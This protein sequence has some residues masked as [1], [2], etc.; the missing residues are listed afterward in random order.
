VDKTKAKRSDFDPADDVSDD[1]ASKSAEDLAGDSDEGAREH[2]VD[3][4]KSKLRKPATAV[5]G[6]QY[7]GSKVG[8]DAMS[9]DVDEDDPFGRD[10]GSEDGEDEPIPNGSVASSEED[11]DEEDSGTPMTDDDDDDDNDDDGQYATAEDD[12]QAATMRRNVSK[13][14]AAEDTMAVAAPLSQAQTAD[15]EK[16]RAV[17][18]QRTTFDSLLG[19]RMKMQKSLIGANTLVAMNGSD[20]EAQQQEARKALGAAER[21]AFNLWASLNHFRDEMIA[22]RTGI[23]REHQ[24]FDI[25]TSTGQ[26]WSHMKTQEDGSTERRKAV[27]LKWSAKASGVSNEQSRSRLN[28]SARVSTIIDVIEEQL[29]NTDRLL[30]RAH[31]PRSCAPL[32]VSQK[33]S[34]D[35]RIYDD[36]DFY[37]LMLKELLSQKSADS[38]TASNIDVNFQMRREAKTKKPVDTKAS[39]GRKL[40]Y[41]VHEKLQN[42]MAPEDRGMWGERQTDELF[43]SLFGQRLEL[44]EKREEDEGVEVESADGVDPAEEALMLFRR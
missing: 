33:V 12:E 44:S 21:A 32:Q 11:G 26:L 24:T 2:Y 25:E 30:K 4:G 37:G 8:R 13:Q 38:V 35:D 39:K 14:L 17:K 22:A 19:A 34:E 41:T 18:R 42:F 16:G 36:A 15:A 40:R 43:G 23:P 1:D 29:S 10:F 3:V 31:T 20:I 27:L 28:T 7:R 9:N 5:L 6:P